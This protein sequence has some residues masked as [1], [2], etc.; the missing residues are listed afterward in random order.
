MQGK[1]FERA[2]INDNLD[3]VV[4]TFPH[5]NKKKGGERVPLTDSFRGSEEY[6]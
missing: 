1:D 5:S 6:G 4:D 3:G 2:I